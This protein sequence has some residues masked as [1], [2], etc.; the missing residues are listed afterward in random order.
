MRLSIGT[1]ADFFSN[2]YALAIHAKDEGFLQ[3]EVREMLLF[4]EE[5]TFLSDA[6]EKIFL[7]EASRLPDGGFLRNPHFGES[8]HLLIIGDVPIG[9]NFRRS[10]R[11]NMLIIEEN[12]NLTEVHNHLQNLFNSMRSR[13]HNDAVTLM[14]AFARGSSLNRILEVGFGHFSNPILFCDKTFTVLAYI[15]GNDPPDDAMW[16]HSV[17]QGSLPDWYIDD[18]DESLSKMRTTVD[19][20]APF[21]WE[22]SGDEKRIMLARVVAGREEL[23]YI[24]VLE[25]ASRFTR[26]DLDYMDLFCRVI[27]EIMQFSQYSIYLPKTSLEAFILNLLSNSYKDSMDIYSK[28]RKFGWNPKGDISI[29]CVAS[30]VSLCTDSKLVYYKQMIQQLL[31]CEKAVIYKQKIVLLLDR[32]CEK[33]EMAIRMDNLAR[34]LKKG[35]MKAYISRE[36][37]SINETHKHFKQ[38][39]NLTEIDAGKDYSLGGKDHPI[40]Y[41]SDHIMYV[42]LELCARADDLSEYCHPILSR[43]NQYDEEHNTNYKETL[44]KYLNHALDAKTTAEEL[45]I[46]YNTMRYRLQKLNEIFHIDFGDGM[47]MFQLWFSFLIDEQL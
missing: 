1:I 12:V 43:L 22:R 28:A 39:N 34:M 13:Y 16:K 6:S 3:R 35:S 32:T 23:G 46:H 17:A 25:N 10:S 11:V 20:G 45:F 26:N 29:V 24:H 47:L 19:R 42:V 36:F 40:I 27:T 31:Y 7:G 37:R 9:D 21:I 30:C 5:S 8:L 38:L 15:E 4:N 2:K 18:L 33:E 41:Y 44:Y 14:E